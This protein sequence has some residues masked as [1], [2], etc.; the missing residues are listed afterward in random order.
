MKVSLIWVFELEAEWG[1]R[2]GLRL[3]AVEKITQSEKKISLGRGNME[4][5]TGRTTIGNYKYTHFARL[6]MVEDKI[7]HQREVHWC[8]AC[9]LSSWVSLPQEISLL[10]VLREN[11]ISLLRFEFRSTKWTKK[12]AHFPTISLYLVLS[13]KISF[14]R[15]E[16]LL[17]P[18]NKPL[19]IK[20]SSRLFPEIFEVIAVLF[21]ITF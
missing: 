7:G 8:P 5:R 1:G 18:S 10:I 12:K 6:C 2:V 19:T 3:R 17:L 15:E 16:I 9:R 21:A 14:K 11:V 4:A 20:P 13:R